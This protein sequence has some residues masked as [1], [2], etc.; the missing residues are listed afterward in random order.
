MKDILKM[1]RVQLL[2]IPIFIFFKAIRP[3]VLKNNPPEFIQVF[4]LSFP[5]FCEAIIGVLTVTMIGL[6]LTKR[7]KIRNQ[8]IYIIAT[9]LAAIFV[10]TQEVKIHNLGGNNIYDPYDVV[11][12]IIGLIV[13]F[14]IIS[15]MKPKIQ[16]NSDVN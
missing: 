4:L 13:G 8:T 3:S 5:N 12:S 6:V 11:F 15:W 1:A 10:I 2:V 14:L 9:I 7:L 16:P